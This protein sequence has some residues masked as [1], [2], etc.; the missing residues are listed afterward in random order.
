M[1][2]GNHFKL[3]FL[4]LA[5]IPVYAEQLNDQNV[6]V[7]SGDTQSH[8]SSTILLDSGGLYTIL[9]VLNILHW[10]TILIS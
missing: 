9:Y 4:I 3:L 1:K 8:T 7:N 2:I 10:S 5:S 6:T